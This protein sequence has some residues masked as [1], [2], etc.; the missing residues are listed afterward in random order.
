MSAE[1]VLQQLR[2]FLL[3]LSILLFMGSLTELWLVGH[4]ED[5]IQWL[6]FA[7]SVGG[8]IVSALFYLRPGKGTSRA[9]RVWMALVILGTLLGIYLHVEGNFYFEREIAP[10]APTE[11]LLWK[12]LEGG[13]PLLAPGI[14]AVAGILAIAATYRHEIAGAT[15]TT[16]SVGSET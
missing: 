14:L 7:L 15:R 5:T 13:N 1:E 2:R 4:T 12:A 8:A 3:A 10:R 16:S 11:E 6:P 9:L